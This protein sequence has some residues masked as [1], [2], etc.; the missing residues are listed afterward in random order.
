MSMQQCLKAGFVV[1]GLFLITAWTRADVPVPLTGSAPVDVAKIR[2]SNPAILPMTGTWRFEPTHGAFAAGGRFTSVPVSASSVEGSNVPALAF[3]GDRDTRWCASGGEMPQ[4]LQMDM[5][6]PQAVTGM[7]VAWENGDGHYNFNVKASD[8]GRKWTTI[9]DQ[10]E[11]DGMGDGAVSLTPTTAR[12]VRLTVTSATASDGK[13]QYASIRELSLHLHKDGGDVTWSPAPAS[14]GPTTPAFAAASFNDQG[15]STMPVPG[16]WE[17]YGFSEPT[18]DHADDAAGLYRRVVDVP[19]SFAGQRVLWHFDAVMDGAEVFVNGQRIGYHEGGF[20][21]WDLDIT[22]ALRPGKPNVFALRVC[23][24]TPSVSLDSG[25][26][27]NLGGISRDTYLKAVPPTHV[28]DVTVVTNLSPSYTDATL[29]TT[30]RIRGTAGQAVAV[31]SALYRLDGSAVDGVTP[32]A[33]GVIGEDGTVELQLSAPVTKPKLWSAEYPNLYYQ[34]LSLKQEGKAVESVQQ[35]FGFK[36]IDIRDNVLLWN[37]VPIKLTGT[38]RHEEWSALGHALDEHAEETD[39]TMIK[40]ANINAVRTSH[41]NHGVRFLELCD[42]KG[43]YIL[44]EIPACFCNPKDLALKDAFVQHAVETLSRD[45]NVPCV[46]AWS[47]GNESGFGPDFEAMVD[48]VA[49][50]DPTRPRFV[51]EQSKNTYPKISFNDWHYPDALGVHGMEESKDGPWIVT[52]GPHTFYGP[53][54]AYDPGIGDLWGEAL[55]KQWSYLWLSPRILGGFIWEWQDQGL[56]DPY[57]DPSKKDERGVIHEN[58][59]GLVDGFRNPKPELYQVKEVYSPITI[60]AHTVLPVNGTCHVD[61]HNRYAFT[62]LSELTCQW[63]AMAGERKLAAGQSHPSCPPGQ[64]ADVVF[65]VPAGMDALV[66]EFVHPDGRSIYTTRL[67]VEGTP[68]PPAPPSAYTAPV[69]AIPQVA[70]TDAAVNIKLPDTMLSVDKA[71]GLTTFALPG[72]RTMTGPTLNL[73]EARA[74]DGDHGNDRGPRWIESKSPPLLTRPQ[75]RA[76]VNGDRVTVTVMEDVTLAESPNDDLGWLTYSMVIHP[77]ANI[78]LTYSLDWSANDKNA[79]ELGLKFALPAACDRLGW[80]RDAP[81]TAYPAD[82]VG[83]VT[84]RVDAKDVSFHATKRDALWATMSDADGNGVA[85]LRTTTTLHV[86]GT[87][88]PTGIEL[89]ASSAAYAAR[90]FSSGYLNRYQISFK[91]NDCAVGAFTIRPI[92]IKASGGS[93]AV[94]IQ[95]R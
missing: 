6:S 50:H 86:R 7:D 59:K 73:G 74:D 65:N 95:Q 35:R 85:L 25:D 92:Q 66:L 58:H 80:Y 53:E 81:W 68:P 36:Q 48:Y 67:T 18:Y 47:C 79:W 28:D 11:G 55:A 33:N 23:K 91:R 51:S 3:D 77:D 64:R 13:R 1:L 88:T 49:A 78:D 69:G 10:S 84:G 70:E 72:G 19:A 46:L 27:W 90:S 21:G 75:V 9:A 57:A 82:Y 87:A 94:A 60:D 26:F 52:E 31:T 17:M 93:A 45:K 76:V 61:V 43:L 12:F 42:E 41:Y 71:T 32:S 89:L 15:W 56:L 29:N 20:T 2:E 5:G 14:N 44:D 54:L 38:C 8:D 4:W 40:A 39:V 37:G 30:V 16:N 63:S 22:D 34:V 24:M 62:D 83:A